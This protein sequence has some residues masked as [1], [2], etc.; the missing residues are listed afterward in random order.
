HSA[1]RGS[2]PHR[3]PPGDGSP[4]AVIPLEDADALFLGDDLHPFAH[5][6]GG[7]R[8]NLRFGSGPQTDIMGHLRV[9]VW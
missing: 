9:H 4:P 2:R 3:V 1:R 8:G 5:Q 7:H 6:T